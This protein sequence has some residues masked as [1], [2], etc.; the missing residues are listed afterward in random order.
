MGNSRTENVKKNIYWSYISNIILAVFS[1]VSRTIFIYVLGVKYL[2]VSGLFSNI[3]GILSFSNLGIGTAINYALYKPIATNDREAIKSLMALYKKAYRIIA[4]II[5]L[6][7]LL[8]CPFLDYLVNTDI[9]MGEI[10]IFYLLI[11]VDTVASY[12]VNYKTSY[13]T[14]LQKSYIVTNMNTIFS[15]VTYVIQLGILLL[16]PSYLLY[17]INQVAVG[18]VLKVVTAIYLNK[19]YPILVEKN[20]KPLDADIKKGIWKNVRALIIHKFG[21]AAVSQTDNIIISVFVNT[22]TVGLVTNYVTL[23]TMVA[24]F[25]NTI[26]NSFTASFG[27]L[28][29]TENKKKQEEIFDL[30]NFT[31]FWIYGF[32]FIAFVT[33]SQ[34]FI[35]LWLG[36][37]L[38]VDDLTMILF[39]LSVFFQGM[40]ITVYNFKV[41]AGRFDEDKWLAFWQAIVNLIV[42]IVCIKLVGLPGVYIGTIAQ[43]LIV[44]IVRPYIV[45]RYVFEESVWKYYRSFIIRVGLIGMIAILM[46]IISSII[47][48][49][50]SIGRFAVLTILTGIIP[51][52]IILLVYSKSVE[53]KLIISKVFKK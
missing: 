17:L 39:F 37:K 18:M 35:T 30:Y 44:V 53:L 4:G 23:Q 38:L 46:H 25:T 2:G 12:F 15:I 32:V 52:I 50:I 41:A 5:C 11:L 7:G 27:N 47:I 51:N 13:V 40:T 29:A 26:F 14:A 20:I 10:R 8:V 21:D 36:E 31:G 45:Y 34:P 24:T 48:P 6:L 22:T 3:L 28:I 1:M 49:P 42:S 19:R 43:R 9:P 16:V 33:L